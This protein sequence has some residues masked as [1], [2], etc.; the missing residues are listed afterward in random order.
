MKE[1]KVVCYADD[2]ALIS[3]HKADLQ[4]LLYLFN[5]TAEFLNMEISSTKAKCLTTSK[6]LLK[7]LT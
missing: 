4:R 2:A 1:K 5:L 3:E 7:M 6:T